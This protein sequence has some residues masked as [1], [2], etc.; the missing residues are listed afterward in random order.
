MNHNYYSNILWQSISKERNKAGIKT[1]V[2]VSSKTPSILTGIEGDK[3]N[4][5]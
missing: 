5:S 3:T 2:A 4:R 1:F